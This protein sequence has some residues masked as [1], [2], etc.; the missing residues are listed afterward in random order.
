MQIQFPSFPFKKKVYTKLRV[1]VPHSDQVCVWNVHFS[2]VL[3]KT[4]ANVRND[5]KN[6][7]VLCIVVFLNFQRKWVS[8]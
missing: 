8:G 2:S 1:A 6:Y 7:C 4:A 5:A 3:I